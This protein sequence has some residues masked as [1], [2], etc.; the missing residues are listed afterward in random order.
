MYDNILEEEED[1]HNCWAHSIDIE[2]VMVDEFFEACTSA[3]N[4]VILKHIGDIKGKKILEL[5]CGAGEASVYFAKKGAEVTA[6]DISQGMLMVVEKVAARHG[7]RVDTR[8]CFSD[9]LEFADEIYD[10]VYAANLLHHVDIERTLIEAKRV[11]KK[12]GI[13]VSWDPLA[14]NPVINLYRKK[15]KK[16]RTE[17]EHP[18]QMK[19]IRL[20][21]KHFAWVKTEAA[22]LLTLWIFVSFY[23]FEKTDPNQERYWKKILVDHKRLE[24]TYHRLKRIDDVILKLFPFMKRY[25]W[26]IVI[27]A[28]K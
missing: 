22:W 16:V 12:G 13:F 1:F 7:V 8:R 25:C 26:N 5:G 6:T 15:A 3:E 17:H 11:L 20:F 19:D 18:L 28:T 9:R 14:H 2:K 24:K 21:K 10:I 23:L 27:F 4:R